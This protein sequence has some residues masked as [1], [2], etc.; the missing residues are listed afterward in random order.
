MGDARNDL[1]DYIRTKQ[2]TPNTMLAARQLALEIQHEA[3]AVQDPA[4]VSRRISSRTCA[5]ICMSRAK[6][7]A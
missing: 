6:H 4:R 2:F 1:T 3:V 7:C 5:M